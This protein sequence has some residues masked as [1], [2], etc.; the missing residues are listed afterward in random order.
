MLM[1]V[2]G[3]IKLKHQIFLLIGIAIVMV[4]II[5]G[6]YYI[7]FY[8]IM[9]MRA[10]G[11][12][13]N[14][15]QKIE[16]EITTEAEMLKDVASSVSYNRITQEFLSS[17]DRV[18]KMDLYK[19]LMELLTFAK[20]NAKSVED[21]ILYDR[22]HN[23]TYTEFNNLALYN[24]LIRQLED[25]YAVGNDRQSMKE[26]RSGFSS[27]IT[28]EDGQSLFYAYVHPI[29]NSTANSP[30]VFKYTGTCIV[31]CKLTT[32][33][34][35]IRNVGL[36]PNS[37][38]LIFDSGNNV[39]ANEGGGYQK[40]QKAL[41][42]ISATEPDNIHETLE[43]ILGTSG[44]LVNTRLISVNGWRVVCIIPVS[45]IT[46]DLNI[47]RESGMIM[48]IAMICIL[49]IVGLVLIRSMSGPI[50]KIIRFIGSIRRNNPGE[51]LLITE[52][53]EIGQLADY[54]NE[55]LDNLDHMTRDMINTQNHLY[56]TELLKKKTQLSA[57]QSQINPHFLYNTL[58]CI[59]SIALEKEVTEIAL[60]SSSMASIFRYA[61]KEDQIV[62]IKIELD[63][64]KKYFT[65][66]DI[67]YEGKFALAFEVD[68]GI[69][70]YQ[71]L[72][73]VLQPIVE[74]AIYH[75]LETKRGKGRVLVKGSIVQEKTICF[76]VIDDG[77]G[78]NETELAELERK[79]NT[80]A[81]SF[82]V[83]H[84]SRRSI[85][86]FNINSRIKI[87]YGMEYGIQVY[88]TENQG[89]RVSITL[90]AIKP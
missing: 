64:I 88:S 82:E 9:K 59:K 14:I 39:V 74:N 42:N 19:N 13:G 1:K 33:K 7:Q 37:L 51:R 48:E 69:L 57:L 23:I 65:V 79:L 90:P 22:E 67:R 47:V 2:F 26:R 85:G 71:T 21:I 53:N 56:R 77:I 76:E 27:V 72:K 52:K 46:S 30:D 44:N 50:F 75:G 10:G 15:M 24:G 29:F 80:D 87:H 34:T 63:C 55:M 16:K 86:L 66:M 73:M 58:D 84:D 28:G 60:I 32:V 18:R 8:N 45:E 62:S 40:Y 43:E 54:I 68:E 41:E 89:T 78:M 20:T 81:G 12:A 25:E 17:D 4:T 36:T 61:I 11:Y 70:E 5:Q 6:I 49:F 35:A 38:F 83:I 3:R 31:L